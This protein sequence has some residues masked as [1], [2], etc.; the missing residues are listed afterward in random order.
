MALIDEFLYALGFQADLRGGQAFDEQL[1]QI[2]DHGESTRGSLLKTITAANL[3]SSAFEK[4]AEMAKELGAEFVHT[5]KEME[6]TKIT[7]ESMYT[8]AAEG[9][10]RFRWLLQFSRD[11]PVMGFEAAK[12][13]FMALKNNGI[14]PT[15]GALKALGDAMSAMP[16]V[17]K[18]I[19]QGLAELIEGR[20]NAGGVLSPLINLH[21]SG[22][23]RVYEGS[24][25]NRK[26]E[27]VEV[28]LDFNNAEKATDQFMQIMRERF[29]GTMNAHSKTMTGLVA[30]WSSDWMMFQKDI[31]D[32]HVFAALEEELSRLLDEWES[33]TKSPD[34]KILLSTVS[35]MLTMIVKLLGEGIRLTAQVVEWFAKWMGSANSIAF[36]LGSMFVIS[37]WQTIIGL[38]ISLGR[39]LREVAVALSLVAA[40]EETVTALGLLMD[41]VLAPIALIPIAITA[42]IAAIA[43]LITQWKKFKDGFTTGWV[44]R[45]FL[46]ISDAMARFGAMLDWLG[47]KA[48]IGILKMLSYLPGGLSDDQQKHLGTLQKEYGMSEGEYEDAAARKNRESHR[49]DQQRAQL[50]QKA[51]DARPDLD[52]GQLLAYIS[53]SSPDEY[54]QLIEPMLIHGGAPKLAAPGGQTVNNRVQ[55]NRTE[56]NSISINSMVVQ[57]NDPKE[58]SNALA[59]EAS[60]S[61]D[62]LGSTMLNFGLPAGMRP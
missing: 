61:G 37:K 32:N 8:T 35:Q 22:K 56:T 44:D 13:T 18:M 46:Y 21:G 47:A 33:F 38:V 57:A 40:G 23:N 59:K 17:G 11:N 48:Q 34:A 7:L 20:Y 10:E 41:A 6:D 31:M 4:G 5:A 24:Y 27:K 15:A 26:G 2:G 53:K 19:P 42:A 54:K 43:V 58:F 16:E 29:D 14:E 36:I 12:E 49:Q 50:I 28:E 30:R 55:Q 60:K 51:H 52:R 3:L 9:E 1:Q 62:A 39:Y 25:V 45:F